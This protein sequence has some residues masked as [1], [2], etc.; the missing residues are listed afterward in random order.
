L[1]CFGF[2]SILF[3]L[4]HDI[5]CVFI[6]FLCNRRKQVSLLNNKAFAFLYALTSSPTL[7]VSKAS[8]NKNIILTHPVSAFSRRQTT[9]VTRWLQGVRFVDTCGRE[10]K[11]QIRVPQFSG[12]WYLSYS[13]KEPKMKSV[14][15]MKSEIHQNG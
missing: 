8:V 2:F 12:T 1:Y 3:R 15:S 11:N 10:I 6:R 7:T 9:P 5:M 14:E 13:S 4:I